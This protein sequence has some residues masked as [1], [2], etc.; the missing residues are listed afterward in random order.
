[1]GLDGR[2]VAK[3]RTAAAIH[4]VGKIRVPRAILNKPIGLTDAEFE[5]MRRHSAD[6]AEMAA[7]IGDPDIAAMVRHHHERL[8]GSGYPDRS[9][10]RR[11]HSGRA[12]SRSPTSSTR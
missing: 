4:D 10:E 1:M 9:P 6:G 8:D 3:I 7:G 11:Y 12:S 5:I 2:D